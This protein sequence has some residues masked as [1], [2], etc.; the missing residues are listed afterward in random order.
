MKIRGGTMTT[1]T[2]VATEAFKGY[3]LGTNTLTADISKV[4]CSPS[5]FEKQQPSVLSPLNK[6]LTPKSRS[7]N[8]SKKRRLSITKEGRENNSAILNVIEAKSSVQKVRRSL[9]TKKGQEGKLNVKI[10]TSESKSKKN[11]NVLL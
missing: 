8:S 1:N 6:V 2:T 4:H 10:E 3:L 7:Q 9:G 5:E 11:K